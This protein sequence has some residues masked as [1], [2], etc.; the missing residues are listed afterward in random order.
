MIYIEFEAI[1]RLRVIGYK[2]VP[3]GSV[4]PLQVLA[5]R[6]SWLQV[7]TSTPSRTAIIELSNTTLL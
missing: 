1:V 4:F 2:G 5:T 3:C 6:A 7:F